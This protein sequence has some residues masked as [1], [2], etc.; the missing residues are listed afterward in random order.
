MGVLLWKTLLRRFWPRNLLSRQCWR[1]LV[2]W[3]SCQNS[4]KRQMCGRSITFVCSFNVWEGAAKQTCTNTRVLG[5][6]TW[7]YSLGCHVQGKVAFDDPCGSLPTGY[8]VIPINRILFIGGRFVEYSRGQFFFLV[9]NLKYWWIIHLETPSMDVFTYTGVKKN[10]I[11][12]QYQN[13]GTPIQF[14]LVLV[15]LHSKSSVSSHV[16]P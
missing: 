6:G 14:F 7:C 4:K 3:W 15:V 1:R 13:P 9:G 8:S 10:D 5:A 11:W 2:N 12:K 16:L